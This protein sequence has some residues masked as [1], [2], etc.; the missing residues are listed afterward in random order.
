[1]EM[2]FSQQEAR[3]GLRA[4]DGQVEAAVAHI[5]KRKQVEILSYHIH[6]YRI[7]HIIIVDSHSIIYHIIIID[8]HSKLYHRYCNYLLHFLEFIIFYHCYTF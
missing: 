1:M 8:V 6:I 3:L 5:M 7:Y 4:C 2:G